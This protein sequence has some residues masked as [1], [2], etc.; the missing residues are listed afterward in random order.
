MPCVKLWEV[1]C[2]ALAHA[3]WVLFSVLLT[4]FCR[5]GCVQ[6]AADRAEAVAMCE[7]DFQDLLESMD[8]PLTP[9]SSWPALRREVP[10]IYAHALPIYLYAHLSERLYKA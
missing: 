3:A 9:Q 8:P 2:C 10:L 1:A 6:A 4:P 5:G 7:E